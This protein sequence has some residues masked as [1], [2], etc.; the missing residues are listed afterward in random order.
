MQTQTSQVDLAA[1]FDAA[2]ADVDAKRHHP[3][4][5]TRDCEVMAGCP[6]CGKAIASGRG[7][8]GI[9][10]VDVFPDG[11]PVHDGAGLR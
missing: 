6:R 3:C 2:C 1:L 7:V 11:H 10:R 5:T 8:T 9:E 4:G